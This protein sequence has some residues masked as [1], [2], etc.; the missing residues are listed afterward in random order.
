M[1]T[2]TLMVLTV[3]ETLLSAELVESAAQLLASE[4]PK[5]SKE[6]RQRQLAASVA[7]GDESECAKR[8]R[9]YSTPSFTGART[10]S[11]FSR[12]AADG[13]AQWYWHVCLYWRLSLS[14][15]L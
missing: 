13:K 11:C 10:L 14:M 15:C 1:I 12:A 8:S 2:K 6:C 7:R 9:M 4:W 5:R 3:V